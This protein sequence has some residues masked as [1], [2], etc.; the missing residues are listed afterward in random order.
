ITIF[1]QL[2]AKSERSVSDN[3]IIEDLRQRYRDIAGA[4]ISVSKNS[5]LSS[6]KPVS[7]VIQGQELET[8][9]EIAEQV[10]A[11]VA[12]VPGTVDISSSYEAG[13]PD[14][15][16]VVNRDRAADLGI[17]AASIADTLQTMFNGAVKPG[18]R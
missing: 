11:A 8:L 5:G 15:Q 12:S 9:A 18:K 14:A 2:S 7:L 16:L 1:T 3:A 17:S 6:G 10:Q 13:N 4:E